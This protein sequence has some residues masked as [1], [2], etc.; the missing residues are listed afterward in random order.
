MY[1]DI[2]PKDR[3]LYTLLPPSLL[4]SEIDAKNEFDLTSYAVLVELHGIFHI[5]RFCMY[6]A[7]GVIA[8]PTTT[9]FLKEAVIVSSV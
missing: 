1:N 6:F 9:S 4:P 5:V 2:Q 8:R 7:D 3:S